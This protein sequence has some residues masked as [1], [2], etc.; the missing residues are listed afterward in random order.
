M[1]YRRTMR[2]SSAA[3]AGM[4]VF[5][6]AGSAISQSNEADR[7]ATPS[8]R[9]AMSPVDGGFLRM[10]TDT[11]TVSLCAKKT[12]SWSCETVPD[13]YKALQKDTDRLA[14]ENAALRREL[15]EL[16]RDGGATAK[17]ADRKFELPSEQEIDK[18]LG[19]FEKYVKKF[20]DLIEKHSGGDTPG[21][22]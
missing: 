8:G 15:S 12:G 7:P 3:M 19:Q 6:A 20:K 2:I 18:A 5:L 9:Y 11:G 16:R 22:I 13:D 14:Q 4:A 21:R 1:R 17:S 10:D